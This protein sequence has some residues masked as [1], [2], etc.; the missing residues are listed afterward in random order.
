MN[1]DSY[2]F[3]PM[4]QEHREAVMEVYN[5]HVANGFAAFPDRPMPPAFFDK[6]LEMAKGY[7]AIVVKSGE[8]RV[9]GYALLRPHHFANTCKRTCELTYFLMPDYTRRGIGTAIL[10]FLIGEARRLGVDN[11]TASIS[12]LNKI[13]ID[14]HLK[15]GFEQCG[16]IRRVG[17]K[18]GQDFD[19]VWLQRLLDE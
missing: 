3:E 17:T 14:F 13:S 1:A 2:R 8:G 10:D 11:L 15:H 18:F 6:M 7:S 19:V 16:R 4:T 5:H 12:S 9:I